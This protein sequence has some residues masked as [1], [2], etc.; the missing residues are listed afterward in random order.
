MTWLNRKS[1]KMWSICKAKSVYVELM[2]LVQ[3]QLI[4]L[5]QLMISDING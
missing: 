2:E 4:Q 5:V 1:L 3:L